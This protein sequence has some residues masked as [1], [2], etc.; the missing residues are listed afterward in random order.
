M[1]NPSSKRTT[2]ITASRRQSK[3]V[4][5]LVDAASTSIIAS[6]LLVLLTSKPCWDEHLAFLL[7]WASSQTFNQTLLNLLTTTLYTL[8]TTSTC[9]LL[10]GILSTALK[11]HLYTCTWRLQAKMLPINSFTVCLC[12]SSDRLLDFANYTLTSIWKPF[13]SREIRIGKAPAQYNW[14]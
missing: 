6:F 14:L 8:A 4:G 1:A 7:T 13:S 2:F 12:V 9:C 3:R 10:P 5:S 11:F